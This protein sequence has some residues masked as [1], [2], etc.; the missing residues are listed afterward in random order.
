MRLRT[1]S[2]RAPSRRLAK[3]LRSSP[4]GW[5]P[6]AGLAGYQVIVVNEVGSETLEVD[7]RPNVTSFPVPAAFLQPNTLHKAEVLAI[8]THGNKTNTEATFSTRP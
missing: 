7:L 5:Q 2:S 1:C 4:R 6:I 3:C 8:G